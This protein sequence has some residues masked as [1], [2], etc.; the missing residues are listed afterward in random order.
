MRTITATG[1]MFG[2]ALLLMLACGVSCDSGDTD[3][4]QAAVAGQVPPEAGGGE[5]PGAAQ[6]VGPAVVDSMS[7]LESS[8]RP[9]DVAE[10][11]LPDP[12][13]PVDPIENKPKPFPRHIRVPE[14]TPPEARRAAPSVPVTDLNGRQ[15]T[16]ETLRGEVVLVTFWATWCPPCKKEIPHLVH[17]QE[18]YGDLGLTILAPSLDDKGLVAIK[19]F[20][21]SRPEINYTIIP[22][23]QR[24][25][26]AYGGVNRIPTSFLI[27]KQGRVIERIQGL[28]S[29][30]ELEGLVIAAL[31]EES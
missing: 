26:M 21:R 29:G 28:R 25:G 27:D 16:M 5:L 6:D 11:I 8:S 10:D 30:E 22:S 15:L 23:G 3:Q 19:P 12:T 13:V 31:R 7:V 18:V 14:L 1:S 4:D 9:A 24:L 2:T 20:L 17:L